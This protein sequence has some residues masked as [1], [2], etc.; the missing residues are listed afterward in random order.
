MNRSALCNMKGYERIVKAMRRFSAREFSNAESCGAFTVMELLIVIVTLA[1]LTAVLLPALA[2]SHT[3]SQTFQCLNNMKQ[4]QLA[5]ML[6]AGDNGDLFPGNEAHP[7]P[8]SPYKL[9]GVGP[10]D[11]DLVAGT[12]G[13]VE[14]GQNG[15]SDYPAAA[16]T[17]TALLGVYGNN[18]PGL[19]APL[20]GSIG[21]YSANPALYVCPTVHYVDPYYKQP[22]VR[23]CSVNC[24]V[25]TTPSE[26]H[27]FGNEINFEFTVFR[28]Y[29]DFVKLKSS[30]AFVFAEENVLSLNDGFLFV[31][32]P[33]GSGDRPGANHGLASSLSYADG[34]AELHEWHDY[35]LGKIG[36]TD[37]QWLAAHLTVLK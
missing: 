5:S 7:N 30:D 28:K 34:H 33:G 4:L 18:V 11:P 12:F 9:I 37:E 2:A 19:P 10:Q 23:T 21:G 3:D 1:L 8:L 29:S 25:G 35:V 36:T 13:T 24:F 31:M 26:Q 15:A 32:E 20:H 6:Y 27:D 22:R 14:N 17:N 16:G